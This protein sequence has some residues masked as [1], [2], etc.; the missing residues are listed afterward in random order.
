MDSRS[1]SWAQSQ[2]HRS[3]VRRHTDRLFAV[4]AGVDVTKDRSIPVSRYFCDGILSSGISWYRASLSYTESEYVRCFWVIFGPDANVLVKMMRTED[5]RIASQIV[6]VV[7]DDGYEQVQHLCENITLYIVTRKCHICQYVENLH[8]PKTQAVTLFLS[9]VEGPLCGVLSGRTLIPIKLRLHVGGMTGWV[10]SQRLYPTRSVYDQSLSRVY[11]YSEVTISSLQWSYPSPALI[12]RYTRGY[13][14]TQFRQCLEGP[15][16]WHELT[17][18]RV[19]RSSSN[20][21]RTQRNHRVV[22]K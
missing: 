6:E 18:R 1:R 10:N 8:S 11:C 19:H 22:T 4:V 3:I 5:R 17:R 13:Y 16:Y 20:L 9:I 12:A 14:Q 15:T 2:C 21:V 7:H